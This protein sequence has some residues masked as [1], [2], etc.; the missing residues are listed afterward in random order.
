[1]AMIELKAGSL[2]CE[3][4]PELGGCIAGLW[5]GETPVLRSTPAAQLENGRKSGCYPL[6]PFSNRI[7]QASLVWQGTQH[8]LI[9]N[10]GDEPHAIH[11]VGWQRPWS[12][13]ESDEHSAMLAY[14]HR[15]DAAWPFA[16]DCSQNFRLRPNGLEMV[17]ALTNQSSQP[18]PAGVGW[19][20]Y[21][22]KR[23]RSRISFQASGRWDM[24]PDKL[25]TVRKPSNGLDADC[26][27]LDVDHCYDGWDGTAHLRDENMHVRIHSGLTRLVAF[28]NSTREYVAIEPVSHVNNAVHLYA[29][30][31]S[32]DE[33]G[34]RVL[35]PG[36]SMM[37]QME[38]EVEPAR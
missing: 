35:Q 17:L 11:G 34:L 5:L 22:V 30:G 31:A 27:F 7:G 4:A 25:P 24:G 29:S 13:L 18:A 8:P 9:R 32:A 16:F 20:P 19:H 14:E 6:V 12:V 10:N 33:L 37:A 38:I 1:M 23:P 3:L 36:E 28:T 21:F 2:R 15:S 26:A